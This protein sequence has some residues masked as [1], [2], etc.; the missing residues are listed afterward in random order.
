MGLTSLC[1][2]S[3]FSS[4][5]LPVLC[6][7][8]STKHWFALKTE[9]TFLFPV[10]N[11]K[12]CPN[13]SSVLHSVLR[14]IFPRYNS[15]LIKCNSNLRLEKYTHFKKISITSNFL[16]CKIELSFREYFMCLCILDSFIS[17]HHMDAGARKGL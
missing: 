15:F 8:Q 4:R 17:M 7:I 14:N 16:R 11:G 3:K 12:S 13:M 1:K 10:G 9:S 2:L 5:A 6:F